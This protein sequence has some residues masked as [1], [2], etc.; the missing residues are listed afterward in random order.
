MTRFL[1]ICFLACFI[2]SCNGKVERNY[3]DYHPQVGEDRRDS[4]MS[5]IITKSHD[6]IVIYG[7]KKGSSGGDGSASGMANSYL[8]K[9]TLETVAFMP[10]ISSDSN[11]GAI[12]TDWYSV[13]E[14]PNEQFKFNIFILNAEL[15]VSSIKV[16]AFKQVKHGSG[17]WHYVKASKELSN[18][19]EDSI[20]KKA[21]ALKAKATVKK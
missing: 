15:Q 8:W 14:S 10:L 2:S 21:I 11:G 4:K 12:I 19:I 20:L 18:D 6:P 17:N 1:A 5:S 13:P 7:P 3:N 9:A 16:V